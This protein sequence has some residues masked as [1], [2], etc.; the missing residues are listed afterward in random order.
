[1]PAMEP[2]GPMVR[3]SDL[4]KAHG[5]TQ[6][7]LAGRIVE[8]GVPITGAGISNVEAGNKQASDRLLTAWARALG[9]EPLDVWHGPL[10]KPV[11]PGMPA[12]RSA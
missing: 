12:T 2:L 6:E 7:Q 9:V 10:R 5:W 3:I 1:M 11:V 8:Q 4:R